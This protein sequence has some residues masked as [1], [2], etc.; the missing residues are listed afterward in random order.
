MKPVIE[1]YIGEYASGKSENAVNRAVCLAKKGRKVTLAD[2][3]IVD[4]FYTLRP[5]KK[6]LEESGIEVIAWET[7]ET[8]GLGEAG[9]IIKPE[10]RWVLKRSGD[11]ILDIGYGI[12]GAKTLNIIED[13]VDNPDLKIYLVINVAR[14]MTMTQEDIIQHIASMGSVDGIIN[15][16][17]L[18]DETD[19][20]FIQ[21]G[22]KVVSTAARKL[23]IPVVATSAEE[24]FAGQ[25]G[26]VDCMG[27]PVRALK[28]YM[29]D[30]FW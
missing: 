7:S 10:M 19:I 26:P 2:L 13:A 25:I 21:E 18:G 8:T 24:K 16:S 4:P 15:N 9:N 12:E 20:E 23:S 17:H 30:T 14:P 29:T 1:A 11:I 27:N 22:A 28:R 6:K 5:I 3:D